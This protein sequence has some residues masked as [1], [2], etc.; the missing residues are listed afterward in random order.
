MY[1]VYLLR[2]QMEHKFYLWGEI[3]V[4][5]GNNV[6]GGLFETISKSCEQRLLDLQHLILN[7]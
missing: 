7:K 2:A 5:N 3:K 4:N 6:L 1:N